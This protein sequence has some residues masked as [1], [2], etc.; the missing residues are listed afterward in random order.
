VR[1]NATGRADNPDPAT[2]ALLR[3]ADVVHQVTDGLFDP[4]IQ[5]LWR[6]LAMGADAAAIDRARAT[7][8]WDRVRV[9]DRS[10]RLAAGQALTLNGIAQ[11]G[12]ADMVV[13]ALRRAGLEQALVDTG[14]VA[15]FGAPW[16]IGV[17]DPVH[18]LIGGRTLV[19]G[20]IATSS[21][22]ALSLGAE[23]HIL[24]PDAGAGRLMW[25]TVSVE[26]ESATLADGLSTAACLMPIERLAALRAHMPAVRRITLVDG[27]GNLRTL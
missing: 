10:V 23:A 20:A 24:S 6:A 25:S 26:A 8:G 2:V 5:P 15:G 1:L 9:D 18:G 17:A 14:E 3:T 22:A 4:T 7:V 13:A 21:P 19:A 27:A 12:A 16:R 11:G